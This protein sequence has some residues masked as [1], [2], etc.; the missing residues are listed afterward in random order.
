MAIQIQSDLTGIGP[1]QLTGFFGGW[2]NPPAPQTLLRLLAG[3]YRVSLAVQTDTGEVL[4][5]A[6][7]ISDGVLTA[8]IPLLEVRSEYRGRGIGL[9]LMRHL[10]ARLRHLYAVDLSCD[11]TLF[12]FYERLGFVRG[13]GMIRRNYARQNGEP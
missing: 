4:G 8:F 10:L 11:D 3:S 13:G 7:A 1:E 12:A 9:E 6:Q 5:F 2:P